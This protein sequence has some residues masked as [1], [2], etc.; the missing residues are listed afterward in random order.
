MLQ[1]KDFLLINTHAPY[2]IEIAQTDAHIPLD[3]EGKWLSRY[4]ADKAT[5]IVLYCRSGRWSTVAAKTLVETDY[6]GIWHLDGGLASRPAAA[7]K[8]I[9]SLRKGN[10]L[11]TCM[12]RDASRV[13]QACLSRRAKDR[14]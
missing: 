6:T 7:T 5:K 12:R 11:K 13:S 4:P 9:T 2:G 8:T 3:N 14:I 1:D 10:H